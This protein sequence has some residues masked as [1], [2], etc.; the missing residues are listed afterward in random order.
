MY[1][2][3]MHQSNEAIQSLALAFGERFYLESAIEG[4][5]KA[6]KSKKLLENVIYLHMYMYVF[7]NIQ[8]Y[9]LNGFISDVAAQ[10][11]INE[12]D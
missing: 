11:I 12:K 7:S 4:L 5:A 8:F 1:N 9:M 10:E 2:V 6:N 3:W